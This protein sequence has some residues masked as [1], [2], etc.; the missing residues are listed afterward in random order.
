MTGERTPE[1]LPRAVSPPTVVHHFSSGLARCQ[2]QQ[3]SPWDAGATS[4]NALISADA[5]V[6]K[7]DSR[8]D[9]PG[10]ELTRLPLL[11]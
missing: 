8:R 7:P 3:A 2:R 1:C 11:L 6:A 9:T 5:H 4:R 10:S